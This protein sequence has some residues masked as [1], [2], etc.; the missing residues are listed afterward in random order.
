MQKQLV[1]SQRALPCRGRAQQFCES[2]V[3][4]KISSTGFSDW[5]G[6][7]LGGRASDCQNQN[8]LGFTPTPPG[9]DKL[10][11]LFP[12]MERMNERPK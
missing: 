1:E 7:I 2:L 10:G 8:R 11:I 3:R 5:H 4:A 6:M 12:R 9:H